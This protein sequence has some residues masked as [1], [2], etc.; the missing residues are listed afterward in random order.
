LRTT[1]IEEYTYKACDPEVINRIVYDVVIG[2][3]VRA[4]ARV[5]GVSKDTVA[6]IS[7]AVR[8]VE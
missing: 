5:F 8:I 6:K 7:K 3:S 2:N 1:F 4:T